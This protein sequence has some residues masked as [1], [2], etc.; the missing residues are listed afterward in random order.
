MKKL[1]FLFITILF[2]NS[3]YARKYE[4]VFC[5]PN[6]PVEIVALTGC[7]LFF[8]TKALRSIGL[9]DERYFMYFEDF[10]I[11]RR[12]SEFYKTIYF[13]L[14]EVTHGSNREHRRNL[15]LFYYAILATIKYFNKW[16]YFDKNRERINARVYKQVVDSES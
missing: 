6:K 11:C 8:S 12:I 14:V 16:G 4:M 13:P 1:L 15:K 5:E 3:S 7:F 2:V 10:D 9:F